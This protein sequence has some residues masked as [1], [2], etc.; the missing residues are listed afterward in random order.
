MLEPPYVIINYKNLAIG[1]GR[2][3]SDVWADV[4]QNL[5][6][7]M[8]FMTQ[9]SLSPNNKWNGN[10]NGIINGLQNKQTQ[11][12]VASFT[13]IFARGQA[14]DFS[15]SLMKWILK[16]FIRS[17]KREASWTT[18]IQPFHSTLWL[19]LFI[20]GVIIAFCLSATYVFGLEKKLNPNLSVQL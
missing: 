12:G 7:V 19:A 5:E 10:W 13:I 18:Y 17:P 11:I 4:W 16:M 9:I 8:N 2:P 20:L 6:K 14:A 3:V 1:R 15:P